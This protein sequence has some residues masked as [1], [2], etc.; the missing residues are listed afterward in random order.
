ML[1]NSGYSYLSLPTGLYIFITT[2]VSN[3]IYN[4]L[5]T[6]VCSMAL[7]QGRAKRK[8]TG[9][10]LSLHR[11]KKRFEIGRELQEVKVGGTT[12]KTARARGGRRKNRLLMAE[13]VSITDPKSGKSSSSK[14]IE[15]VE[16]SA[17]PNYVRQN[18]ITKGSIIETEKGK[19]KVTSRPGQHGVVN[20]VLVAD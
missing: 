9:G 2:S 6:Q 12:K 16:N 15:V 13:F 17:N 18:I 19:A 11:G 5:V 14:I 1:V 3:L 10:R 4:T 7:W 20:A 8:S